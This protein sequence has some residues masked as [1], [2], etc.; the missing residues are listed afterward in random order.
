MRLLAPIGRSTRNAGPY[1]LV[2]LVKIDQPKRLGGTHK[3]DPAGKPL[4]PRGQGQ[5]LRLVA[6]SQRRL[7]E[8]EAP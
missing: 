4:K 2:G 5:Q 7:F 8:G 1:S 6:K 3:L